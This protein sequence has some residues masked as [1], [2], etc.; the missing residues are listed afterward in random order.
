[1]NSSQKPA[2]IKLRYKDYSRALKVW[3]WM[4]VVPFACFAIMVVSTIL[5]M[6]PSCSEASNMECRGEICSPCMAASN[7]GAIGLLWI[8]GF[9][10]A[11]LISLFFIILFAITKARYKK[12]LG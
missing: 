3:F 9:G 6:P 7:Y 10:V 12:R 4:P 11:S 8:M 2:K 1:M 5:S